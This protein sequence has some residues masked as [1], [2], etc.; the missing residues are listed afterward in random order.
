MLWRSRLRQ[1]WRAWLVLV[2]LLGVGAGA[3]LASVAGARRTA[4]S[5][6]RIAV[7]TRYADVNSGHGLPPAEAEAIAESFEG[8]ASH[9][10]VVGFVGHA[11]GVDPT[12]FKY[13]IGSWEQS[14]QLSVPVLR[15]GRY[16]SPDRPGEVL[17]TGHRA[18]EAGVVPG[19]TLTFQLLDF[20]GRP[21]GTMPVVVTGIGSFAVEAAADSA[22]DRGAMLLTPAFTRLHAQHQ[23]W[24]ATS[25][26]AAPGVNV[27]DDLVPQLLAVGWS[28]DELRQ[29]TTA[30]VQD[31]LRP[32]AATLGLLGALVLAATLVVVGQALARQRDAVR[33]DTLAMRAMGLTANQA[34][35]LDVLTVLSVVGPGTLLALA[36]AAAA[37]PV[38]P[39][40]SVRPL[41]PEQGVSLDLTVLGIGGLVIIATLLAA[42][43]LGSGR[44]RPLGAPA[45]SP[46][47]LRLGPL[48][49]LGTAA[50]AGVR[51]AMGASGGDRR[52]FRATVAVSSLALALV[53]AGLAFVGA[54]DR[55]SSRPA[56][57]GV[58]WDLTARNAYGNVDPVALRDM[59]A[60]DR[61]VVGLAA[62]DL[63]I[64]VLEDGV[65]TPAL[66][67]LPV[68]AD[69]WPTVVDGRAPHHDDEVLVGREVLDRLD[70]AIGDEVMMRLAFGPDGGLPPGR[71]VTISGTA[72]FPSVE[73]A[74]VDPTRLGTGV[75]MTWGRYQSLMP[76]ADLQGANP[77]IAFFDLADG[78]RPESVIARYEAEGLPETSGFS[79][80]DW[81]PSLAPAEVTETQQATGVIW[82]V[83]GFM[84]LT[85]VATIANAVAATVRR[86][87]G[88]YAILK[89][90]GLRRQQVRAVVGW[91]AVAAVALALVVG[92]PLGVA[93]GRWAWR[94]FAG[95]MGVIDTPVVPVVAVLGVAVGALLA[96]ALVALGP[97]LRAGRVAP[98]SLRR[99]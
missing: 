83:I 73:L 12:L 19:T 20:T 15:A 53:V 31:A 54:L 27:E 93:A 82:A 25:L 39:V 4:S 8:V 44:G 49:A 74:G 72:V 16:P 10:T 99:E 22:Y 77:D 68:T 37:S 40:G 42:S 71:S 41:E 57:Y 32:L 24:S 67:V 69:L 86:R 96:A 43:R 58:A 81:L 47:P 23:A 85:V 92:L 60:G 36:L 2:V 76:P 30:R 28:T 5:F 55:L 90:L 45:A 91:Q 35:A 89:A 78:V 56:R 21:V 13:F 75:A 61:D 79:V 94:L 17:V 62:A 34:R 59:V 46:A 48:A 63:T 7:A 29:V 80:T 1:R 51:L 52:R 33:E 14:L 11:E 50:E 9:D 88:D 87:I 64:V 84:V 38:F 98:V 97:G 65:S 18:A 66:A 26:T 70:A 6:G 95:I 3:A